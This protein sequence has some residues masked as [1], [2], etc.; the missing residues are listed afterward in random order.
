MSS[1]ELKEVQ[2]P[3]V[4]QI[5]LTNL[6]GHTAK[7]SPH[8]DIF[9]AG[10]QSGGLQKAQ[11]NDV[12]RDL[13][14][15]CRD[16]LATAHDAFRAL[17]NLSDNQL[18]A[19]SL[20]EA[21]FMNFLVSYILNAQATLADLA[22]MIL[23]NIT[24]A[25]A[26]CSTLLSMKV[27]I[28]PDPK[29]PTKYFPTQS[30]S[31]TCGAPV[32]YPSGDPKEVFAL[33][34]LVDA[35]VQGASVDDENDPDKRPRKASLHFLSSVFANLSITPPGRL[36][37]LTPRASNPLSNEGDL[38]YPLAKFLVFTE[39][40]DTIRR[41]GVASIMKNCAF[42]KE[43]H[44]AMLSPDTE[45]FAIPP[46]TT[47]APGMDVLPYL[48]LP[49][50]G[51]EEYD[52]DEQELLPSALQFLPET[53]KR[54]TDA[55]IRLTHV[56]TLLLLCT[57]FW[58]REYLRSHGVYEVVRTLHE[59]EKV[60]KISEH[61]ERL[62]NFLKRDESHETRMDSET[63]IETLEDEDEDDKIVEV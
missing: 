34:L 28:L 60:D 56:E 1:E 29:S 10:L 22:S 38:E 39:H 26:T 36:F 54:E 45:K 25:A 46:S 49:L 20:S 7:D 9:L 2:N 61:V 32:P 44:R 8:R 57:T 19:N 21:T 35:F 50:A 48:L 4:R 16:Q 43:A 31:G 63:H 15:L 51:P 5:A 30:R 55:V 13:K 59:N 18:V 42:H 17:V 52:L 3:Q 23:S 37:F 53:K 12:L 27:E 14:I 41:G 24:T 40:K 33:P 11:D 47:V 62:V 58:A 6:L